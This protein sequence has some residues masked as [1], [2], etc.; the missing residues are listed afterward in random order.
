MNR[1]FTDREVAIFEGLASQAAVAIENARLHE[2]ETAAQV[3]QAAQEERSRLARDLH[4]SVTQSLF[5]ATLKA[6]ALGLAV[7]DQAPGMT[8]MAEELSRLSRGALAQMRTMLLELRGDPVEEVPLHQLLRNLVEAAESRAS[9]RV[10]LDLGEDATLP[11]DVH[12]AVYRI[13]QEALNN[14]T[15]HAKAQNA[16]VELDRQPS[17]ARLVIGD[18]G[19]GFDPDSVEPGHFGLKSVG[20]RA[21]ESGGQLSLRSVQGEGT[22]RTVE[23]RFE[24][25]ARG[26]PAG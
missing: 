18:D 10:R 23:W 3:A 2:A 20:E 5:A 7:G 13:T 9:V 22:A 17:R 16:W 8:G 25:S 1:E 11:A 4:D 24:E 19:C 12:E 21:D 26:G 6:E 15:R 14:V